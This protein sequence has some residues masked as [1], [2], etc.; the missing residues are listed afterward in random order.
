[1]LVQLGDYSWHFEVL[2]K[3]SNLVIKKLLAHKISEFQEI[4][5]VT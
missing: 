1:M 3:T 4:S 2:S 5:E